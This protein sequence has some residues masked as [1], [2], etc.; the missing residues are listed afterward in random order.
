MAIFLVAPRLADD[1]HLREEEADFDRG[2]FRAVRAMHGVRLDVLGE[3]R[4][5]R[6]GRGLLRVGGAHRLAIPRHGVVAFQ[7]LRDDRA[8]DH[9]LHQAA[10]ERPLLVHRV[11]RLG[12]RLGQPQPL[13]RDDAQPAAS[14]QALILPVRFRRVASGLMMDS[15][16]SVAI[17][18]LQNVGR[19][20]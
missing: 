17:G 15:V 10:K 3:L 16:R 1:F 6:A 12:L 9:E 14:R 7:D 5:D 20:D 19:P 18:V 8:G 2:V 13:L 11:E 4:A